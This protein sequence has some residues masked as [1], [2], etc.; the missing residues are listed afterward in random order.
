MPRGYQEPSLL[1]AVPS[2]VT[3]APIKHAQWIHSVQ[4][5]QQY[6]GKKINLLVDLIL[7]LVLT[8][9]AVDYGLSVFLKAFLVNINIIRQNYM[10][11]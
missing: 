11:K 4:V 1:E 3:T 9:G 5:F 10:D 8:Q 2:L 6:H 7:D